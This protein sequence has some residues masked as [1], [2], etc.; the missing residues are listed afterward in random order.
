M[1]EVINRYA[2]SALY[3]GYYNRSSVKEV[4]TFLF[5]LIMESSGNEDISIVCETMYDH[6]TGM[7]CGTGKGCFWTY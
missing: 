7:H 1:N 4:Q 2:T 6:H 3:Q 5:D